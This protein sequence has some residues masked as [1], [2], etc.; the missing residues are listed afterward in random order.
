MFLEQLCISEQVK[1]SKETSRAR[2]EKRHWGKTAK[3]KFLVGL[4]SLTFTPPSFYM[5]QTT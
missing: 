2:Q 5:Q 3:S 1:N 4:T